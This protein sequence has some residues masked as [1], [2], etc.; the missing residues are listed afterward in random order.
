[1]LLPSVRIAGTRS[2]YTKN[3]NME[4]KIEVKQEIK[5]GVLGEKTYS[6]RIRIPYGSD[7]SVKWYKDASLYDLDVE[8]V[9][10]LIP[11]LTKEMENALNI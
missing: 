10:E 11:L 9:K 8:T 6:V 5:N 2:E 3:E 4:V 7:S 1:M